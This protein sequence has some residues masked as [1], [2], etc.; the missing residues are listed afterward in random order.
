VLPFLLGVDSQGATGVADLS[1]LPHLLVAGTTGSGK[2]IFLTSI[3][4][5]LAAAV[6]PERLQIRIVDIKGVDFTVFDGLPHL[7]GYP[8]VESPQEA[9]DLLETT[10][11]QETS[12]RRQLFRK[13]GARQI[14]EYY[15]IEPD[16]T[17]WPPQIVIVIDEYAQLLGADRASRQRLEGLIQQYAQFARAFGIYLVLATQRPSVD[18]V[19]GPIKANLPS[20][21]VFQLPSAIDSRT[22]IDGAGAEALLGAGD[23]LF[24][25]DG[26]LRR[27]QAPNLTPADVLRAARR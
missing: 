23:M 5:S 19:T 1:K 21:C 13:A 4:G 14:S 26:H 10:I 15:A 6:P 8:V 24:Y 22:V 16:A 9:I 27:Y 11:E 20:R 18:V 7:A 12:R 2:S 3:L 25:N 17:R